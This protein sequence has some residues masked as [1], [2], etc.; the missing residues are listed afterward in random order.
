MIP[1]VCHTASKRLT[2]AEAQSLNPSPRAQNSS[3][4]R[5]A[6]QQ[7]PSAAGSASCSPPGTSRAWHSHRAVACPPSLHGREDISPAT[8]RR[9]PGGRE[10]NYGWVN[11]IKLLGTMQAGAKEYLSYWGCSCEVDYAELGLTCCAMLTYCA[12]PY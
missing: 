5:C 10:N 6:A 3:S 4:P 1:A 9:A 12:A 7:L 2:L 11:S 8:K